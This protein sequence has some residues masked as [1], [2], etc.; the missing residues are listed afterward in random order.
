MVATVACP[1]YADDMTI[2]SAT[3]LAVA[4]HPTPEFRKRAEEP[5]HTWLGKRS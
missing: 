1:V 4:A 2:L 3:S 5:I